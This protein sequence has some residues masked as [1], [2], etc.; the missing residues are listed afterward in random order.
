M[1]SIA[2]LFSDISL[3]PENHMLDVPLLMF[4]TAAQ[5]NDFLEEEYRLSFRNFG[6]NCSLFCFYF[7]I[8]GEASFV[9]SYANFLVE[10]A[11]TPSSI[12]IITPYYAQVSV[13]SSTAPNFL[14]VQ[15]IRDLVD[16]KIVVN[17]VDAFQGQEREVILFSMV[18]NNPESMALQYV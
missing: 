11:V 7:F 4:N 16:S 1:L 9:S 5:E 6:R 12:G 15:T 13:Q 3:I 18:R 10:N 14:Q 17:T 8:L 2:L